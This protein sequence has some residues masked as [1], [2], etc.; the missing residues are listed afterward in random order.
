MKKLRFLMAL[1]LILV[2][3]SCSER[4]TEYPVV[5]ENID[6]VGV[7]SNPDY[8]RDGR[9]EYVLEEELAIGG[10]VDDE[11]YIFHRPQDIQIADDGT[12]YV[13][14]W[15]NSTLK[16]YDQKGKYIRTIGGM[17]QGPAEFEKAIQFS[18]SAGGN[19][20]VL[21]SVRHRVAVLDQKGEY[22]GGFK[23]EEGYL[24]GIAA[25]LDHGIFIGLQL[26]EENYEWLNIR[27]YNSLGE[28]LVD[29]GEFKLVQRVIKKVKTDYGVSTTSLVSRVEATTAWKVSPDGLLYA[30]FGDR[31]LISVFN[32]EGEV[33]L[34]FGREYSPGSIVVNEKSLSPEE[35]GV[36][37][38]V[39]R[40]WIFDGEGNIWVEFFR[41]YEPKEIVYDVFSPEGIYLNQVAVP[42]RIYQIFEGK[43]FCLVR[44]ENDFVAAKRFRLLDKRESVGNGMDS[45][46]R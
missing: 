9:I 18:P 15:G 17:G 5:I 11:N 4:K 7:V 1:A 2:G 33:I 24:S 36:F 29:Y 43:A 38:G 32:L 41:E 22:R 21:D 12:I 10:D 30:A 42:Y 6:G 46:N 40:R 45:M 35:F 8:P 37:N 3:I 28:E 31:Y 44:D 16:L 19:V 13:M 23:I 20:Y 34:K 14:D 25:V 39:A 27:R 26:R